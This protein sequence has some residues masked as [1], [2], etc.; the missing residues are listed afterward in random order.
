MSCNFDH[1]K[2]CIDNNPPLPLIKVIL[3]IKVS[4]YN[5]QTLKPTLREGRGEGKYLRD[6]VLVFVQEKD[7]IYAPFVF[8]STIFVHDCSYNKQLSIPETI[9]GGSVYFGYHI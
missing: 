3:T 7:E 9:I 6:L 5:W 8:A 2:P 4:L 1:E